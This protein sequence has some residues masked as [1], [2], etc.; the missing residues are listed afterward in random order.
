[1]KDSG[2]KHHQAI[3]GRRNGNDG[4]EPWWGTCLAFL[5]GWVIGYEKLASCTADVG[6]KDGGK[7]W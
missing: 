1:M 4:T 3:H 6:I 5:H 2:G 7:K